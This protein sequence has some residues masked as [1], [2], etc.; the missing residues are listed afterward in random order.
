M[1]HCQIEEETV[2]V[3]VSSHGFSVVQTRVDLN[4][5]IGVDD[6]GG[7][8]SKLVPRDHAGSTSRIGLRKP[9]EAHP[10]IGT[11]T[12]GRTDV[13]LIRLQQWSSDIVHS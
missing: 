11:G 12:L 7:L 8:I 3:F 1:I 10:V 2:T 6:S 4:V 13:A 5:G 9:L